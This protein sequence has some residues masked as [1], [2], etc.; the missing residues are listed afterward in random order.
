M[1]PT[2]V[3]V[4]AH[5]WAATGKSPG[6]SVPMGV[7]EYRVGE[8]PEGKGLCS[9]TG[10]ILISF[11]SLEQWL[12]QSWN[13]GHLR[14]LFQWAAPVDSGRRLPQ[15]ILLCLRH[16][17]QQGGICPLCLMRGPPSPPS[18]RDCWDGPNVSVGDSSILNS[19]DPFCSQIYC[20]QLINQETPNVFEVPSKI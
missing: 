4:P 1:G 7:T 11:V 16:G 17:Q 9:A 19:P 5:V 18:L 14:P 12:L 2:A 6:A 20:L 15:G 13:R 10:F 3:R 8:V